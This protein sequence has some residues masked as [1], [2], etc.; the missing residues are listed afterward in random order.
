MYKNYVYENK[1]EHE[2]W[3]KVRQSTPYFFWM[4]EEIHENPFGMASRNW[5][6]RVILFML[7]LHKSWSLFTAAGLYL[8]TF[9]MS[10]TCH[11]LWVLFRVLWVCTHFSLNCNHSLLIVLWVPFPCWRITHSMFTLNKHNK[12]NISVCIHM[13]VSAPNAIACFTWHTNVLYKAYFIFLV[14]GGGW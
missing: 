13:T 9:Q 3:H 12:Q 14:G 11:W 7:C 8:I 1:H 10:L 5:N 6:V 4:V 2:T